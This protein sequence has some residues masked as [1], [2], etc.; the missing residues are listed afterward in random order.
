MKHSFSGISHLVDVRQPGNP[1]VKGDPKIPNCFD[2]LYQLSEKLHWSGLLDAS[3]DLNK[4][5][6]CA[7]LDIDSNPPGPETELQSTKVGLQKTDKERW[8]TV[9]GYE[10]RVIRDV[11]PEQRRPACSAGK[12]GWDGFY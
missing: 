9:C 5:N 1:G 11:H 7:L 8:T 3:C 2:P 6:H 12:V 10:S 4:E